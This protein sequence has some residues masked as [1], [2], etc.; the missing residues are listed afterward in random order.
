VLLNDRLVGKSVLGLITEHIA[1]QIP[2]R[3][4]DA[5][6]L[7]LASDGLGIKVLIEATRAIHGSLIVV[8]SSDWVELCVNDLSTA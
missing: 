8:V 2:L 7:G 3:V 5:L 6:S 1:A 4:D